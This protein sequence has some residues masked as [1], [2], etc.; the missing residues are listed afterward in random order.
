MI[1]DD[2]LGT[3]ADRLTDAAQESRYAK[4]NDDTKR[5]FGGYN[6][7][8]FGDMNQLPPIPASA[9]LF[10]PPLEKKTETARQALNI[11]WSDGP[12]SLNFFQ[13]LTAQYALTMNGTTLALLN[14][15][16]VPCRRK[17]TTSS[18]DFQ[19]NTQVHGCLQVKIKKNDFFVNAQ[20]AKAYPVNGRAWP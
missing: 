6:F 9:A 1:S 2:L 15:A 16:K 7:L 17:C 20:L 18:W 4:R 11:S 3:F 14:A 10:R 19:Q 12:D 5:M 13:D 8:M